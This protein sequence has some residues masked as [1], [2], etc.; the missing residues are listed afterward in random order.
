MVFK[1]HHPTLTIIKSKSQN[2]EEIIPIGA[3][4]LLKREKFINIYFSLSFET[5]TLVINFLIMGDF[6]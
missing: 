3:R 5:L 4:V 1:F 2:Y 6:S